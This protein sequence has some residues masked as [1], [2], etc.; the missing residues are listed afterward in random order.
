VLHP[1]EF[2]GRMAALQAERS[3]QA[4]LL[5]CMA[6]NPFR[7]P[8][9]LDPSVLTWHGGTVVR[10]AD[11]AYHER[12]LPDGTLDTTRLAVL[13]DALEE[14][15]CTDAS[16]LLHLRSPGPHVRGCVAIDALL[17]KG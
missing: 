14:A 2:A 16:L 17:A 13:A 1:A 11:A 7:P 4:A 3:R 15:G 6:G 10:L 5:R 12:N 9:A 8:P